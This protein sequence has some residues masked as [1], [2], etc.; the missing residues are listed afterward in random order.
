MQT[1]RWL[2]SKNLITN[3]YQGVLKTAFLNLPLISIYFLNL[4]SLQMLN[5]CTH[6]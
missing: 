1:L 3:I 2:Y 4:L 6:K 5:L